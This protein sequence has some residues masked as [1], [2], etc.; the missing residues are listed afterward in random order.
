[1]N[2][3]IFYEVCGVVFSTQSGF[4]DCSSIDCCDIENFSGI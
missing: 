3:L 1:M 2:F 4:L